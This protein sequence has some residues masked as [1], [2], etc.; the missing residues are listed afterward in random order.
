M[1]GIGFASIIGFF[2]LD[3]LSP[4]RVALRIHHRLRP[5]RHWLRQ[6]VG[7]TPSIKS[8]SPATRLPRLPLRIAPTSIGGHSLAYIELEALSRPRC[9]CT[10]SLGHKLSVLPE[11][12]ALSRPR[13]E[14]TSSSGRRLLVL[15]ESEVLIRPRCECTS[16]S[17]FQFLVLP[18]VNI[19]L[20]PSSSTSSRALDIF[21]PDL[22]HITSSR[23]LDIFDPDLTH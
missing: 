6:L 14:C 20:G 9:E 19:V 17:G 21:D 12:E 16:S 4:Q 8:A 18:E 2:G 10:S 23:V 11:S 13:Y 5:C 1:F 22:A 3:F 15:P 7:F